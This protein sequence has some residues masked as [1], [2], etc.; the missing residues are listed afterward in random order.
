[1]YQFNVTNEICLC[2]KPVANNWRQKHECD[3]DVNYACVTH[4]LCVIR[5]LIT[6]SGGS[7]HAVN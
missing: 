2:S 3:V 1:M 7:Q 5:L 6:M 4:C